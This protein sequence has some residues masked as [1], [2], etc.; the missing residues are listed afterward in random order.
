MSWSVRVVL[1]LVVCFASGADV[2]SDEPAAKPK[3]KAK[4]E[5]RWVECKR[6]KDVTEDTGFQATCD[7]KDIVYPHKKP[8]LVLTATEVSAARLSAHDFSQS[9]GRPTEYYT[10]A[11][12]LTKD[13]RTK[14]A[15]TTEGNDTKWLTVVIDGK[16]WCVFR[17]EKDKDKPF[18]PEPARAETF[19]PSVG[20]FSTKA[21]A[22][23]LVDALK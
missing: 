2:V 4:V 8:A 17:Y 16:Y 21:E 1:G 14:L 5:L 23:R 3:D 12:H 11:L 20:M 10:V 19:V 15:A 7:P 9:F 13:A 22:Q 6:I 18:V